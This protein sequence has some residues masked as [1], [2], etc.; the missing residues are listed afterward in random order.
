MI[1]TNCDRLEIY[2]GGTHKV[3]SHPARRAFA[4]LAY[5]PAFADLA[6]NGTGLPELRIDGYLRRAAGG[7]GPDVGRPGARPPVAGR[8]GWRDRGR[9][10]GRHPVAFRALDGLGTSART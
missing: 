3:T 5:P 4:S 8:R 7:I 1:A 9:R 6:V 2:V 10:D